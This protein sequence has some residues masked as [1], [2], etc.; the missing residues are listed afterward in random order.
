MLCVRWVSSL[1]SDT[2]PS[3]SD[4]IATTTALFLSQEDALGILIFDH[5]FEEPILGSCR[6]AH[7]VGDPSVFVIS[8]CPEEQ[9]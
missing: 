1:A 8:A 4:D 7:L 3:Y 6:N 9:N 2:V 5:S